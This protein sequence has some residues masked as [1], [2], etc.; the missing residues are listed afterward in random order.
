[1]N[2]ISLLHEEENNSL[3]VFAS[4]QVKGCDLHPSLKHNQI[5]CQGN[6]DSLRQSQVAGELFQSRPVLHYKA[7]SYISPAIAKVTLITIN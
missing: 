7:H 4:I 6:Y 5:D 1:M 3:L 2:T